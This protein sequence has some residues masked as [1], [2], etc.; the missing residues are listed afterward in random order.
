MAMTHWFIS[1]SCGLMLCA[2]STHDESPKVARDQTAAA[3]AIQPAYPRCTGTKCVDL[4]DALNPYDFSAK[5]YKAV[6]LPLQWNGH[7]ATAI[8]LAGADTFLNDIVVNSSGRLYAVGGPGLQVATSDG[9]ARAWHIATH[10]PFANAL[11]GIAL[12]DTQRAFA[13]GDEA[14]ILRTQDAGGH[15][16]SF[17]ATFPTYLDKKHDDLNFGGDDRGKAFGVAFA[18]AEHGVVVGQAGVRDTIEAGI[19]RTSDGG[20]HWERVPVP[21]SLEGITLQQ[22][23]FVDAHH[24]WAVGSGGTVLR[25]DDAGTHWS[26]VPLDA[27]GSHLMGL[28]FSGLEHGCIGGGYKV[29]CTWDGGKQ[30]QP[31]AVDLPGDVDGKD[32]VAITRLRLSDADHGW[33]VTRNGLIFTS[34]DGGRH[35]RLWMN[36]V[37]AAH[38]KLQGVELWGL[39]LGRDRAWVTGVGSFTAPKQGQAQLDSSPLILSWPL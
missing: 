1:I 30:W 27:A 32:D 36:V 25:T 23:G 4:S 33:F 34:S 5:D 11:N 18:D 8:E 6:D 17:N 14:G 37:E 26:A 20:Q 38:G 21:P 2:C 16:E 3:T 12:V 10:M 28:N 15:W 22:V 13:V 39:A 29:W 24:G 35:W 7:M 31:A 9:D 19:L